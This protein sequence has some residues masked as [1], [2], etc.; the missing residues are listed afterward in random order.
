MM[1]VLAEQPSILQISKG[2][3]EEEGGS[4]KLLN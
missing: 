4:G 2:L 1:N 3:Q